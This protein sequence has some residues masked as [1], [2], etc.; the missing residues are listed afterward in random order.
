[1]IVWEFDGAGLLLGVG[2][3]LPDL[4]LPGGDLI[5]LP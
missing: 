5:H 4:A 3:G 2:F 1:M